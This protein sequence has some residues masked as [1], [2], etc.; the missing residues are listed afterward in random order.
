MYNQKVARNLFDALEDILPEAQPAPGDSPGWQRVWRAGEMLAVAGVAAAEADEVGRELLPRARAFLSALLTQGEL[1]P[2]ERAEAGQA[3]ALLGDFRKGVG[4]GPAASLDP[5]P[6]PS[7][8]RGG[9]QIPPLL[10]GEGP[11]ERVAVTPLPD[12]F[13]RNIPAGPFIMGSDDGDADEKPAHSVTLPAFQ[14]SQYPITNVQYSAFVNDGGYQQV[15]YWP[16]AKKEGYWQVG[17]F[18][19]LYDSETRD[20][21]YDFGSPFN[22]PN[23]P[24]VGVSW[25]EAVAFCRWLSEQMGCLVR[26]PTEAEW[27]KAARG[28]DG[29]TYPWDSGASHLAEIAAHCNMA[30]TGINTTCAVGI[31]PTGKSPYEL[32]DMSGN[33]WEWCSTV[34]DEKGYPFKVVEEWTAAYLIRTNV[35]RVLRGGAFLDETDFVRCAVRFRLNP[36]G[37]L[38]V[39]GFRVVLPPK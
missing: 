23:H 25:Y 28:E 36:V 17:R 14:I 29:R 39:I 34:W 9:E 12:I 22:L 15:K 33:V 21:P 10:L 18:K 16:E 3:L 30:N 13:W 24:V 7:S 1:T 5:S 35:H 4:L 20:C 31:F 32:F 2:P 26:L 37:R 8:L 11:G 27:E 19:G 38:N 6:S